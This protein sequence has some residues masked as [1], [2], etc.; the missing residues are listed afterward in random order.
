MNLSRTILLLL[1]VAGAGRGMAGESIMQ[2]FSSSG[3]AGQIG[4]NAEIKDGV[5]K[6]KGWPVARWDLTPFNGPVHIRFRLKPLRA[7][8][9]KNFH[10][11]FN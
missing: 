11:G 3:D 9:E 1:L 4:R 7:L 2:D 10:Y 5:L 8:H 6:L